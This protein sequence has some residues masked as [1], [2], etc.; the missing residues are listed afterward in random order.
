MTTDI[1]NDLEQPRNA[2]VVVEWEYVP[3]AAKFAALHPVWVDIDGAC[4]SFVNYSNV[5]VPNPV[6]FNIS[7]ATPWTANLSGEVHSVFNHLHDGGII[8]DLYRND[9]LVCHG[10]AGYGEGSGYMA[11][12]KEHAHGGHEHMEHEHK[13]NSPDVVQHGPGDEHDHDGGEDDHQVGP[14]LVAH[15]SSISNCTSSLGRT[16]VGDKWSVTAHYDLVAHPPMMETEDE[17]SP[18]MGIAVVFVGP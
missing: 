9:K 15:I 1:M 3:A 12:K 5:P 10:T 4:G 6:S 13:R 16:D 7:M 18:I 17:P 14:E 11:P 8:L 2:S